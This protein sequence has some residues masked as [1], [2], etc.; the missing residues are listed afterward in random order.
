MKRFAI[1]ALFLAAGL[2]LDALAATPQRITATYSLARNA[3]HMADITETFVQSK[4]KYQIESVTRA[5]GIFRVLTGESIRLISRGDVTKTGLRPTHFE[6]HRG[7]RV[8]KKI[9]ADFD[10]AQRQ[11]TFVYDG[12]TETASIPVGL[13]DRISLMYQFMF[14]SL[15]NPSFKFDMSNGRGVTQY[16]YERVGDEQLATQAGT[17]ETLHL[18]RKRAP[19]DD[20]TEVWLARDKFQLPVKV[21]IQDDKGVRMEQVLTKLSI[22]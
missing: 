8:D 2:A 18:S 3:Q 11:A 20:G 13:Q 6:H 17:F 21:V 10:W 15:K 16:E 7:A 12:K 19:G 14:L 22:Q 5:V 9:I 4:G 1:I